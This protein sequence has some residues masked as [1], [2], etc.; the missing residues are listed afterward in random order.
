MTD[1]TDVNS[2]E[3][4]R[5][6]EGWARVLNAI[7]LEFPDAM[8]TRMSGHEHRTDC[9]NVVSFTSPLT[10]KSIDLQNG[11]VSVVSM[12]YGELPGDSGLR[13]A[14]WTTYK[15]LERNGYLEKIDPH[16]LNHL[17]EA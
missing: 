2:S 7:Q 12:P 10:H 3:F 15:H 8:T 6:V 9:R 16:D 14:L 5:T 1:T 11:E 17:E 4:P 13:N